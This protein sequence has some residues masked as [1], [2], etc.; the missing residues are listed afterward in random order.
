MFDQPVT[1]AF[2][3]QTIAVILVITAVGVLY[4]KLRSKKMKKED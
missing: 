2:I 1:L 4:V 3:F